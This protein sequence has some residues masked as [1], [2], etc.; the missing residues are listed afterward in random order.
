[1]FVGSCTFCDIIAGKSPASIRYEDERVIVFDNVLGWVPVMLLVAPKQ[2]MSQEELWQD[3]G[4]VGQVA[5]EMGKKY[6]PNGFRLLSNLG[7][8]AMQSQTHGHL[9]VLGGTHLGLYV[10]QRYP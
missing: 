4:P 2:H 1:V 9:H 10:R 6:C 8:D 7:H 3:V 5:V